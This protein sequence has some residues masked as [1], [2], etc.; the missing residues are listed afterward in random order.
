MAEKGYVIP[1]TTWPYQGLQ[2]V[3]TR[4]LGAG[5]YLPLAGGTMSGD[6]LPNADGTLD[7]GS[8][9]VFWD[10]IFVD[11]VNTDALIAPDADILMKDDFLPEGAGLLDL[12]GAN[13][14]ALVHATT[15]KVDNIESFTGQVFVK[16]L[17]DIL[18]NAAN[19]YDLG[20]A[21]LY[22]AIGFIRGLQSDT[23][24]SL[25]GSTVTIQDNLAIDGNS[26]LIMS[27]E[28]TDPG[29]AA[30]NGARLYLV[31]N[32]GKTELKVIFQTGSGILITAEA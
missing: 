29:V 22:W 5:P 17:D 2:N 27:E 1:T 24:Q 13:Q 20:T 23:I 26:H 8:S 10:E 16:C 31:D 32:G 7:L 19:T 12:G 15:A 14:W 25:T 30:T 6:I 11:E 3:A 28:S 18:P 4:P 9:S 21:V